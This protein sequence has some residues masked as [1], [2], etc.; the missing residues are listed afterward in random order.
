MSLHA[1]QFMTHPI[2]TVESSDYSAIYLLVISSTPKQVRERH[3]RGGSINDLILPSRPSI[4]SS[5]P[6]LARIAQP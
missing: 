6:H 2:T 4:L 1:V 5:V 3:G